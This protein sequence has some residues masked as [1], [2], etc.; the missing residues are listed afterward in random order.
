MSPALDDHAS[1]TQ[2]LGLPALKLASITFQAF[3][4]WNIPSLTCFSKPKGKRRAIMRKI[5]LAA[6]ALM[7][8]GAVSTISSAPAAAQYY[9]WCVQ[10]GNWDIPGDCSFQTYAQCQAAASGRNVYCNINP[11]F[12]F[13]A[14]QR[15]GYPYP[16]SYQ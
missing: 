9:P 10:G 12:A 8:A 5:V 3:W 4:G 14:P 7:A 11:R 6:L 16:G 2:V 1:R 15:R 13:G